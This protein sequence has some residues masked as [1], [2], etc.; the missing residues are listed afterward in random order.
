MFKNTYILIWSEQPDELMK[1]YRDVLQLPL[2]EKIDIPE[3]NG[4]MADFGYEF[5]LTPT[6]QV[7]IGKHSKVKGKS[8]DPLRIMHNL[9]TDD[10][11]NWYEKVRNAGCEIL[12]PPVLTPFATDE[13]PTY[14]STFLDPEGNAWQFMGTLQ[15]Q[16]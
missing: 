15:P 16:E 1:F 8:K 3:R 10:V 2:N 7:W 14:V 4:R 13:N 6:M 12:T 5:Q 9:Y 11:Q